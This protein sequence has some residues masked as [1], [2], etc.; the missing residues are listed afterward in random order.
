MTSGLAQ[1]D[2]E[3]ILLARASAPFASIEDVWMR[4]SVPRIA[5][6]KL[7]QA[8]AFHGLG[9]SRRQ[10]LW[11][12]R[13]LRDRALP[14]FAAAGVRET[15]REPEVR[16]RAMTGGREVV[17]RKRVTRCAD[18]ARLK[19]G[20]RV[21]VAGIVLI[22]QRPGNGNVTFIT[23]EDETGVANII[24]WQRK[25]EAQRRIVMSAPMIGVKGL[26]QRE[27]QV[28]HI[29]TERLEDYG[30]LLASVGERDFPHKVGR[31][32]GAKNGA[33]DPRIAKQQRAQAR[34]DARPAAPALPL[35]APELR[36]KSRNFH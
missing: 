14:L 17:D 12:V 26:V 18:L 23:I 16:L 25:F 3:A 19:D 21:E 32:D 27:G 11:Q 7:A 8:D 2:A 22:R 5:L 28:I 24:L 35:P 33:Y 36:L 1:K 20:S 29:V 9:L 13:G 30:A 15:E 4:S 6:E 10:A 31:A 34:A